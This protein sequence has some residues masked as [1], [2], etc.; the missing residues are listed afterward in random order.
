MTRRLVAAAHRAAAALRGRPTTPACDC[1]FCD[2]P[3]RFTVAQQDGLVLDVCSR[4]MAEAVHT[5]AWIT[6]TSIDGRS[7][8]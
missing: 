8:R 4:H 6:I 2:D 5:R 7:T 3:A 1:D